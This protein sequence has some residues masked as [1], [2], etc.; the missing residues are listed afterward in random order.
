MTRLKDGYIKLNRANTN[1]LIKYCIHRHNDLVITSQ[2][3]GSKPSD[4]IRFNKSNIWL[5]PQI[6]SNYRKFMSSETSKKTRSDPGIDGISMFVGSGIGIT[7]FC[8]TN[9]M[10]FS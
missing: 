10:M 4:L 8:I 2:E 1:G 3:L 6:S 5:H 9:Y 7:A